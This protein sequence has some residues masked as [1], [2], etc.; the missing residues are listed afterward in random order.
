MNWRHQTDY[1]G[2]R[3]YTPDHGHEVPDSH[4]AAPGLGSWLKQKLESFLRAGAEESVI[5]IDLMHDEQSAFP[6]LEPA[7][8]QDD[9]IAAVDCAFPDGKPRERRLGAARGLTH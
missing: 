2:S 5:A 7:G 6:L 8:R 4:L 1:H 9:R 3:S